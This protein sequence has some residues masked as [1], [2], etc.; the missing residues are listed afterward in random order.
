ML[1]EG[2]SLYVG[3]DIA[4]TAVDLLLKEHAGNRF[5]QVS[6]GDALSAAQLSTDGFDIVVLASV[7]QYFPTIEYLRRAIAVSIDKAGHGGVILIADVRLRELLPAYHRWLADIAGSSMDSYQGPPPREVELS[8]GST[9]FLEAVAAMPRVRYV[10]MLAK[11]GETEMAHFR[12]DVLVHLDVDDR[13]GDVAWRPWNEV[14]S[15][16]E[17]ERLLRD[18]PDIPVAISGVPNRRLT[19]KAERP[20][21]EQTSATHDWDVGVDPNSLWALATQTGRP[22]WPRI[23]PNTGAID[24]CFGP[25]GGRPVRLEGPGSATSLT[26]RSTKTHTNAVGMATAFTEPAAN[27]LRQFLRDRLP[28]YMVPRRMVRV[29]ALPLTANGKV[30]RHTLRSIA[31]V[32][33]LAAPICT[34]DAAGSG[35]LPTSAVDISPTSLEG[36]IIDVWRDVLHVSQMG[37]DDDFFDL[38]GHSLLA[39]QAV[40]RIRDHLDGMELQLRWLFED[41]TVAG[42]A[43]RIRG[44]SGASTPQ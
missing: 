2:S 20:G 6:K 36:V 44:S 39:A 7:I 17:I 37:V 41:P 24:V 38:G 35:V 11:P 25:Q 10:E 15:L 42:L 21:P 29:D 23:D 33:D 14:G 43:R 27:S 3:L 16:D 19:G 1:I 12:C 22:L 40:A 13:K 9:F 30:D 32:S 26:T 5:V 28:A 34:A 31:P 8:V 4:D 18:A